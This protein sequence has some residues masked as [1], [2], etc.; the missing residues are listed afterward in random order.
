VAKNT[1]AGTP[2]GDRLE[3]LSL[4]ALRS[5]ATQFRNDGLNGY[6]DPD[7]LQ[8]G[9]IA[10]QR[11]RN[12]DFDEYSRH[13]FTEQWGDDDG[14]ASHSDQELARALDAYNGTDPVT[15]AVPAVDIANA[16]DE[17][18]NEKDD[19]QVII[20]EYEIRP[21]RFH[22]RKDDD[23]DD[24]NPPDGSLA[25]FGASQTA[26]ASMQASKPFDSRTTNGQQSSSNNS[27]PGQTASWEAYFADYVNVAAP[28]IGAMSLLSSDNHL[29]D[30]FRNHGV[31][32]SMV[33]MRVGDIL[34]VQGEHSEVIKEM[35]V[36]DSIPRPT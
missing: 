12:G 14:I 6:N 10:A 34:W 4:E 7:H 13:K 29:H 31:A 1:L 35:T 17:N 20:G 11:R 5:N 24:N 32:N 33:G 18:R 25:S 15:S 30:L 2:I 36:S 9:L 3:E 19:D 22:H 27:Q 23:Y 21:S 8:Q 26:G 16:P 28:P